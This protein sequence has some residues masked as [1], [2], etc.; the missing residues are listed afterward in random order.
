MTRREKSQTGAAKGQRGI[1]STTHRGRRFW[2]IVLLAVIAVT[3]YVLL[4]RWRS[5]APSDVGRG[6][7]FAALKGDLIVTVTESGG[8]KARQTIDI[9]SEVYG[10]A[11][12]ISL[13][14]EGTYITQE[15]VHAGKVIVEL[16]ASSM[17]DRLKE[18]EKGLASDEASL[19]EEQENYHIQQNQ[20]ESNIT[21]AKLAVQFGL[22]DLQNFLGKS[23]SQK[24]VEEV[25]RDPNVT[26]EV[27]ALVEFLADPNS[28]GGE[29]LQ[30]QKKYENDILLAE[31]QLEKATDVFEGTQKLH[32]ANYA[33]D[34][35]LKSAR[36]DV[37]RYRIQKESADEALR[38]YK[39]YALPK[40]TIQLLSAY[41]EAGHELR[42]TEARARSMMA[43]ALAR[44]GNAEE[45]VIES[46]DDVERCRRQVAACTIRAPAPGLVVYSSSGESRGFED[47]GP[48]QEGGKVY[49][50]QKIISLPNTA[51]MIVEVRVHEA[52]VDKVRPGQRATITAEP[53]PDK[54]FHGEVLSVA[55]L[56]DAQ[57]GYLSPDIKVYTTRVSIGDSQASLRPGMSAKVEIL[58]EQLD[59]V[60][61]VPVQVVANRGG[62]KVCYVATDR[63]PEERQVQTGAFNDNF[64]EIVSGL[65]VGENVL[66][67]PPRVVEPTPGS[68]SQETV[69]A[70]AGK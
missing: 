59:D 56:P 50:R 5:P 16:D 2:L 68:E 38:L 34:L 48:I 58:V 14:P 53:F 54:A 51:E 12:I 57:R 6:S 41:R 29:A 63:G 18:E 62:R 24:L 69:T 61:M 15:D 30:T 26:I 31:G 21:A 40:Q 43:Q 44:R 46:R 20:N 19:T 67:S 39:L 64:V 11:T 25:A 47:R 17:E 36:L 70:V 33:S 10:E 1:S 8:I 52:S 23:A 4:G 13:V 9:R 42:R 3:A 49:Q 66:L 60:L 27:A 65:Q 35:D 22:L 55:P 32:D 37:D 45:E 7:T 28:L